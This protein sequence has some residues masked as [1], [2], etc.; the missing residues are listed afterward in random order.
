M[1]AKQRS[2]KWGAPSEYSYVLPWR[3]N[4]NACGVPPENSVG[5]MAHDLH[6]L[7]Q[8]IWLEADLPE[9][10]SLAAPVKKT[11]VRLLHV[12]RLG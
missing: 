3:K 9:N 10:Y 7:P 5:L 2:L 11:S 1:E 8:G 12:K 4:P 6:D